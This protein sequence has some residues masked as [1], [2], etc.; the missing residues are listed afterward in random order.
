MSYRSFEIDSMSENSNFMDFF[1]EG[2]WV[3][4]KLLLISQNKNKELII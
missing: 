2:V 4:R 1:I 3:I